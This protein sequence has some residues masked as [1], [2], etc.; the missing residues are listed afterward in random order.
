MLPSLSSIGGG[1]DNSVECSI[2]VL[3]VD[4]LK[5]FFWALVW[6]KSEVLII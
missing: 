6:A 5:P 3:L 4:N 1:L 2:G